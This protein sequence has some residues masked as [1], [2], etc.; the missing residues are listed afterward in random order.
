MLPVRLCPLKI[1]P[2]SKYDR[3]TGRDSGGDSPIRNSDDLADKQVEAKTRA[4]RSPA[5]G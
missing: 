2:I 5:N 3:L 4:P 1:Y